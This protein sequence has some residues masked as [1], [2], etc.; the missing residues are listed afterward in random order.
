LGWDID[1]EKLAE[2]LKCKYN[3]KKLLYFGGVE[4]YNFHFDYIKN[5]SVNLDELHNWVSN[6]IK[7]RKKP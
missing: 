3:A 4:T 1:Y 5:D 2:Y 7:E 6:Y